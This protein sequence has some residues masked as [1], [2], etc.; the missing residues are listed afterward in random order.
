MP[1]LNLGSAILMA[2]AALV[3]G[4]VF[5]R[6]GSGQAA[7]NGPTNT[8]APTIAGTA[9]QGQKLTTSNGGWSGSPTGY[10]YVWSRCDASGNSCA[11]IS[12]ATAS[13]YT[14][15]A[16]DVGHT[17][18]VT[19]TATNAGGTGQATSAAS[20]VVSDTTAPTPTTA[21]SISGTL[22]VGSTLTASKGAWSGNP[23]SITV[24]WSRC[25]ANGDACAQ[26]SGA[27]NDTYTLTQAD[28]GKTLRISVVA[29]NANGATT[30]VSGPTGAVPGSNGCPGG[31]GTVQASE[32][33]PPARLLIAKAS[34]TPKP[35]T[36]GTRTI[37]LHFTVTACNGRPVQ[38]A[39]VFATPIPYNQFAAN[40]ATTSATGTVTIGARRLSG[41]PARTRKSQHLLA[42]FA[43]AS[44]PG[45]PILGGVSTRRTVAF[46]V[47]LP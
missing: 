20:A 41:F 25:D 24:A 30:Y 31:T 34:I 37:Q 18:R 13:S 47:N 36:L 19:V 16:G 23:T 15:A 43:R 39:T 40:E 22:Q 32:V 29:T 5:G 28:A 42:V 26:L 8:A 4:A 3:L 33:L 44:K 9:Q 14:A 38:G 7:G 46:Q 1:R 10:T 45:D 12:G 2:A 11:S 17:L 35:V 27:T 6:P 21:P